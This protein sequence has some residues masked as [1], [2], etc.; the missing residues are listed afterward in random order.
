MR[1]IGAFF[2]FSRRVLAAATQGGLPQK[3]LKKLDNLLTRTG[4]RNTILAKGI[5]TS[6]N[7]GGA[8]DRD[9]SR[10]GELLLSAES[11]VGEG[12]EPFSESQRKELSEI[13]G[14]AYISSK[15]AR[16]FSGQV[17]E[18]LAEE[19]NEFISGSRRVDIG[20]PSK[21]SVRFEADSAKDR[22]QARDEDE[23]KK[24]EKA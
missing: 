18:L 16:W 3:D 4:K 11:R 23:R 12:K 7:A 9:V 13:F 19:I 15:T 21:K 24:K 6:L 22:K 1:F 8:S 5:L 2:E 14:R 20:M 10:F 17:D